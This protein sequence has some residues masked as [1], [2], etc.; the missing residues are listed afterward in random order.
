M[1]V[2]AINR[3]DKVYIGDDIYIQL[4]RV[5]SEHQI[6][7]GFEAP[8]EIKIL[9]EKLKNKEEEWNTKSK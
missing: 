3:N 8:K 6:K 2:L 1:L 7:L 9:R 5:N 4:L